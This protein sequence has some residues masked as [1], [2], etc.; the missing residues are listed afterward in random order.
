MFILALI[1]FF[2][3]LYICRHIK[4]ERVKCDKENIIRILTRGCAR[5]ATA[6]LQDKSPIVRV[7]HA[8][9]ATGY[10]W[11]LT[12]IF[13]NRDIE[14]VTGINFIKFKDYITSIQD[15][16]TKTLVNVCPKY[17]SNIDFYLGKIAQE[18]N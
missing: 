4:F 7:L 9:Y 1:A 18:Y 8:N 6:S 10:L 11:A 14:N 15:N 17:A 12:D 5:W 16:A 2:I 3:F 13:S